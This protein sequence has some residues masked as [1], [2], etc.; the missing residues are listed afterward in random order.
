MMMLLI[1]Y[2]STFQES[3]D[4]DLKSAVTLPIVTKSKKKIHIGKS[5]LNYKI[6]SNF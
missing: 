4:Y 6:S 2:L 5:I 3:L 1:E